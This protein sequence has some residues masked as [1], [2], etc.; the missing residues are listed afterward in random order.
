MSS[1]EQTA[2]LPALGS[3]GVGFYCPASHTKNNLKVGKNLCSYCSPA[4]SVIFSPSQ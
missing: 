3:Q 1:V 2:L 4:I